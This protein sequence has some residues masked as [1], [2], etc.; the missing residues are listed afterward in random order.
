M[1]FRRK[2]VFSNTK[3]KKNKRRKSDAWVGRGGREYSKDERDGLIDYMVSLPSLFP[4]MK[5]PE[6]LIRAARILENG[7]NFSNDLVVNAPFNALRT[8][9][10]IFAFVQLKNW[11]PKLRNDATAVLDI[12]MHDPIRV[13]PANEAYHAVKCCVTTAQEGEVGHDGAVITAQQAADEDY[14]YR[15]AF[16]IIDFQIGIVIA[17]EFFGHI[18]TSPEHVAIKRDLMEDYDFKDIAKAS[19]MNAWIRYNNAQ[20][21]PLTPTSTEIKGKRLAEICSYLRSGFLSNKGIEFHSQNPVIIVADEAQAAKDAFTDAVNRD[22]TKVQD[23][24]HIVVTAPA[25]QILKGGRSRRRRTRRK[26]RRR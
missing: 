1:P 23:G 22:L 3:R 25:V 5:H 24:E 18:I 6:E 17:R 10:V 13:F 4:Q 15:A 11:Y 12:N 19:I 26:L 2:T 16:S 20:T 8:A 21:T 9:A 14:A 7:F